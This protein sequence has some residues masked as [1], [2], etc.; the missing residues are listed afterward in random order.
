[1]LLGGENRK[2]EKPMEE[3]PVSLSDGGRFADGS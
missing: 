3:I 1:M 2:K